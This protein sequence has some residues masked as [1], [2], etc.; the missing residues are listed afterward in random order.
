MSQS[1]GKG[2]RNF[3]TH[4]QNAG[5]GSAPSMNFLINSLDLFKMHTEDLLH[6]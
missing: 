6:Q 1:I 2:S 5:F 3:K 4:Q